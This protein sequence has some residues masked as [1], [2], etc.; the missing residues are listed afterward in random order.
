MNNFEANPEVYKA[1]TP[2]FRLKMVIMQYF[3][4]QKI[5]S[6]KIAMPPDVLSKYI[7]GR[8]NI[9]EKVA[10]QMQ[11]LAGINAEFL[12]YG[13]L[14]IMVD[15]AT[16][17]KPYDAKYNAPAPIPNFYREH[18]KIETSRGVLDHCII[19]YKGSKEVLLP[20]GTMNV[21]NIA[22]NGIENG[23]SICPTTP[24][25][26]EKYKHIF[27]M[28]INSY[29]ILDKK[30]DID[31]DILVVIDNYLY[32]AIYKDDNIF[33]DAANNK[34]IQIKDKNSVKIIGS[35]FSSVIRGRLK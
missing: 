28:K 24:E 35:Y 12:L 31:E 21:V 8:L 2:A 32:L 1:L 7:T 27:A 14:P 25:F 26:V 17:A 9:T 33:I 3:K 6:I 16:G 30:Y 10:M 19:D 13:N 5:L 20:Q 4:T 34:E 15:G 22:V 29:L 18:D 23:L 11:D